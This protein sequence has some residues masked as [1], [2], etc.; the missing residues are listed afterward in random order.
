[1]VPEDDRVNSS[2][3]PTADIVLRGGRRLDSRL[4]ARMRR[5]VGLVT[6]SVGLDGVDLEAAGRAG[7]PVRNV[8]GYCT[9]EV[10]DHAILLILAALRR[11]PHWLDTTGSGGWLQ[12]EDQLTVRRVR[13]LT[14]GIVGAGRIGRSVARK[15]GAFGMVP[16]FHDPFVVEPADDLPLVGRDELLARADVIVLCA[17]GTSGSLFR[18]GADDFASLKSPPPVVV[19]VARGAMIDERALADALR[20]GTV[21][22]AALD[23]RNVEPPDPGDDPLAGAPNLILTPHVAASSAAAIADLRVGVAE[24]AIELLAEAGRLPGASC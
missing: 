8:P 2:L 19:N 20:A 7:I 17:S 13:G 12:A 24:A 1:V 14:V 15:A 16:I 3:L 9:D 5:C 22:S 23:V 21:W 6:Y 11:L 10:S 18:L 4:I